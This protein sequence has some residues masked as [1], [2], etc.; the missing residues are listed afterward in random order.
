MPLL[1]RPPSV[2]SFF[3]GAHRIYPLGSQMG[4]G[5]GYDLGKDPNMGGG[6]SLG[7]KRGKNP[8]MGGGRGFGYKKGKDPNME[9]GQKGSFLPL[10][11]A[12]L[13]G[14]LLGKQM[15]LGRR[16]RRQTGGAR[17][18]ITPGRIQ[19][20]NSTMSTNDMRNVLSR[21]QTW[22]QQQRAEKRARGAALLRAFTPTI[23]TKTTKAKAKKKRGLASLRNLV[24]RGRT[25]IVR[26]QSGRILKLKPP[27][28]R[29]KKEVKL[30]LHV[31]HSGVFLHG[32]KKGEDRPGSLAALLRFSTKLAHLAHQQKGSYHDAITGGHF[33][34]Y[35]TILNH[36]NEWMKQQL[37]HQNKN[38]T[39]K[40]QTQKG[41][42]GV[43]GMIAAS[44]AAP[45]IL[46]MAQPI[47]GGLL[48]QKV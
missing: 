36:V 43:G 39:Q 22:E 1:T 19:P 20:L 33:D 34:K 27:T 40:Q 12:G 2:N 35:E 23:T 24:R 41:G 44:V 37:Q 18:R 32:S 25:N 9:D 15:G 38:S 4:S 16:R 13:G 7:Y 8:N 21:V 5:Y 47:L 29:K 11:A 6:K 48:G 30:P 26:S 17:T 14:L 31:E 46:Q 10:I 42:M 3:R 28:S 45:L